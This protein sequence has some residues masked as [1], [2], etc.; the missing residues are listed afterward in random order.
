MMR[1][2]YAVLTAAFSIG[3]TLMLSMY[4]SSPWGRLYVVLAIAMFIMCADATIRSRN[5]MK[6]DGKSEHGGEADNERDG[7]KKHGDDSRAE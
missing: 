6:K 7:A 2:I 1:I 4:P 3:A 5:S